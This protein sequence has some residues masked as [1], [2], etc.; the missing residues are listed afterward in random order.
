VEIDTGSPT[1]LADSSDGVGTVTLNRPDRRNALDAAAYE[2][3][4][5]ILERFIGDPDVG[6]IVITGAGSAFCAG[7]DV[8][9]GGS[10][11]AGSGN[12][13][14]ADHGEVAPAD[15]GSGS[16]PASVEDHGTALARNARMVELLHGSPKITLA[17][18][19]GPAVGAGM[20]IAL[21]ADLRIAARSARLIPGWGALGFSGDF[22]GTWFL[23]RL[24]GPSKALELLVDN[25]TV[26]AESAL[27]LGLV[28]RVV[29]DDQL[30]PAAR[31]WARS[32]A[33]GPRTAQRFFKAN[34]HQA[35]QVPLSEA[36]PAEAERMARSAFTDDHRRAVKRWLAEAA[37]QRADRH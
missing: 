11:S 35:E 28:N 31:Q 10:G 23:T 33:E 17:A 6:C 34:V 3:V 24:V 4:P 9:A 15:Q 37:A 22:G 36:L 7:G 8:A 13:G 16:R 25:V 2:V 12:G 14:S 18:L 32:I 29:A 20:S 1:V 21:A 26:D 19:P 30:A 5:R 27:A